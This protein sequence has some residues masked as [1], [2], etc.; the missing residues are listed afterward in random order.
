MSNEINLKWFQAEHKQMQIDQ[1]VP[2]DQIEIPK[3][4]CEDCL[5]N[6]K[7]EWAWDLYNTNGDCLGEK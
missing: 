5:C 7:C 1:G 2:I 3:C 4:T 6:T